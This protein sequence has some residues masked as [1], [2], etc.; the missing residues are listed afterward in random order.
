MGSNDGSGPA[1]GAMSLYANLLDTSANS[2]PG[3]ISKAPVM[4]NQS[5]ENK[6]N[7]AST[8]AQKQQINSGSYLS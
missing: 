1:R 8:T 2:A 3:S 6:S 7:N 5:S 4:F